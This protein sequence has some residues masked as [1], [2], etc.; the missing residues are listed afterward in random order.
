V[1]GP[2]LASFAI[3]S[4]SDAIP[5]EVRARARL[6]VL[7]TIGCGLA[8]VG[9]QTAGH[10][11]A[12]AVAEGGRPEGSILGE[13]GLVPASV[14]ALANGTR[15]H[16]L[17]FDDTHEAGICHV[18]T[19]VAPAALA[20]GEACGSTGSEV[21]D[22]YILGSEVALRI[23]V[24]LVDGLYARGFHPTSVCGAF[25]AAAAASRLLELDRSDA[26]RALG[27]VGSFASGLFE[28]LSDGSATKP[29]HAGWAAQAGIRAAR[30]AQAGAT[31]PATVI[32][33]RFGLAASHTGSTPDADAL[34]EGLGERWE[35]AN[36]SI[37]PFPACHFAHSSTWAAAELAGEHGLGPADIEEIVVRVPAEGAELVLI[38]LADKHEP[39]TVYDAKFSLPFTVAHHLI[40]GHLGLTAFSEQA[41]R[42][43][44]VL[45]L[46]RRVR[47]G[48]L[49]D[50]PS[51][52]AG[53]ARVVTTTGDELDRLLAHAPGSPR[54][55]LD[56]D[57]LLAKF[58]ANA[59][60]ALDAAAAAELA[61]ALRALDEAPSLERAMTVAR[62]AATR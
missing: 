60:L 2:Q 12:V 18:S 36:V 33:G 8:A 27:I 62:S 35:I 49:P 56:E 39:R 48:P 30:L 20:V 31:G 19:V 37:K 32:E 55:P 17:D 53:S 1:I 46:A 14:A 43:P 52:F 24:A 44:D 25:G 40:H 15:C 61:E 41:I 47:G 45:A 34:L 28:Y 16:G 6:H 3:G 42:D 38:P 11:T 13:A 23:A 10:A 29:L 4:P 54:N 57:W 58:R 7:D 51:R 50:P 9:L 26:A 21:L 22:A 59:E 5:N